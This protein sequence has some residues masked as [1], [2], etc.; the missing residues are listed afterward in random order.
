MNIY[1]ERRSPGHSFKICTY[2]SKCCTKN[3]L[4]KSI[5]FTLFTVESALIFAMYELAV[6]QDVQQT[7]LEE[8]TTSLEDND[9]EFNYD[10]INSMEY[11]DMVVS[12]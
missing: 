4:K 3:A 1:N 12:G 5:F 10:T 6:N 2:L 7:L 11:L 8:L 9:G